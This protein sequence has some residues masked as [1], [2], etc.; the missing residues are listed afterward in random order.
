M[1]G[2]RV[3]SSEKEGSEYEDFEL[4]VIPY[5]G[6]EFFKEFK[7][8]CYE[9]D[10]L[11][12]NWADPQVNAQLRVGNESVRGLQ[13]QWNYKVRTITLHSV[14]SYMLFYILK[15]AYICM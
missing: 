5:P 8:K 12:F 15:F 10:K 9:S 7:D 6:C 11:Y 14:I 3:S 13:K 2:N 1:S 4:N